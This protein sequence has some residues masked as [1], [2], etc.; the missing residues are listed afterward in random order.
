M[1]LLTLWIFIENIWE[2]IYKKNYLN[3]IINIFGMQT[4]YLDI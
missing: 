2:Q 4:M 1:K 3:Q